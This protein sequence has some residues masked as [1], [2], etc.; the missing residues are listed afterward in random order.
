MCDLLV[1]M[2]DGPEQMYV[3]ILHI[4]INNHGTI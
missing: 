1:Y 4:V 3:I 2:N